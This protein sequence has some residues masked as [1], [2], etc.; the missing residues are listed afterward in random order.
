MSSP[1]GSRRC[2]A[3]TKAGVPCKAYAVHGGQVCAAHSGVVGAP[4]GNQNR[5]T[6]GFY[7]HPAKKMEGISDVVDDLLGKQ[8]QLSAYIDEQMASGGDPE[9]MIKLFS[10]VGQNA[11]RL[12]RLLRDQ[13]A[14]SGKSADGLFEALGVALDEIGTELGI[15]L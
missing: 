1:S 12:G 13:R 8:E 14:L 11:S 6:H 5:M 7:T 9:E 3:T 10:L 4:A 15:K 2:S